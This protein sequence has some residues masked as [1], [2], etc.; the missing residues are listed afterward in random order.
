MCGIFGLAHDRGEALGPELVQATVEKLFKLSES[1]G[2]EAAGLAIQ[3]EASIQVYKQPIPASRFLR[4]A[5]YR[6]LFPENGGSFPLTV[7]GHSRLV[8]NGSEEVHVNNQPVIAHGIAGIHN[9]IVVNDEELWRRFPAMAR[10]CEVDSEVIFGLIRHQLE[11][12]KGLPEAVYATFDEIYGQASIASFFDDRRQ[13][14]LYTNNG[15]LYTAVNA[16]RT[17]LVFASERHILSELLDGGA[18]ARR[19]GDFEIARVE[20]GSGWLVDLDAFALSALAPGEETAAKAPTADGRRAIV[21]VPPAGGRVREAPATFTSPER[22]PKKLEAELARYRQAIAELRRCT[23]CVLPETM[24]FISFDDDGVCSYCRHHR[25]IELKP[26]S[27]LDRIIASAHGTGGGAGGGASCLVGLS[28]GRDSTFALHVLK[29]ELGLDP[30]AFTYDW[31]MVTELARRNISRICG[32]LGI[33]HVLVSADIRQKRQNI[34]KNVC[35][36]LKNPDLGLIPLFMAGDKQYFHYANKLKGQLGV[37]VTFLGENLL[38]RTDFKTG[39]CGIPPRHNDEDR[40]YV[41]GLADQ[42]RIQLYYGWHYLRNPAFLNSSIADTLWAFAAYYLIPRDY[43]NFYRYY[44]WD[45]ATVNRTITQEYGWEL[46]PDTASTWRIGDGTAAFYNYVYYTVAGFSEN[47]TLRSNQIREGQIT[48]DDA[49]TRVEE[50][51]RPRYESIRWYCD[52]IGISW[53]DALATVHTI[54]KR[55]PL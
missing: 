55:Y 4:D 16:R 52:T 5:E 47:E 15:S 53:V 44:R 11:D 48:R 18:L 12:G 41:L 24:P 51:N 40:V 42:L 6:K 31:G 32:K 34:R 25:K 22:V 54:P 21:D 37:E 46:A 36:W 2:K 19:L 28:G 1:R 30:V 3:G 38:E 49:I 26:R 35:A 29:T 45:E 7:I 9:G 27:E 13:L 33:E 10:Q 8:T 23:R 43:V 50:E 14:L 20:P 39:Y 17:A